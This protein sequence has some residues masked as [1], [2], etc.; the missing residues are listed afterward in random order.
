MKNKG[1]VFI[2]VVICSMLSGCATHSITGE[3]EPDLAARICMEQLPPPPEF[4]QDGHL[5]TTLSVSNIA[6]YDEARQFLFSYYSQYPDIDSDY[7]AVPVAIK[8]LLLPWKW[9]WRNDIVGVLHSQYGGGRSAIDE[10]RQKISNALSQTLTDPQLDWLSGLL[11]HAYADSYAHTKNTFNS[12]EEEAYNVWIGHA[13]PTLF[14][15]SPDNIKTEISE[16]K[17]FAYITDLYS[18]L[19]LDV[20]DDQRFIKF[21]DFVDRL[22]CND[23]ACPNFNALYNNQPVVDTRIDEFIQCMNETSRQLSKEEIQKAIDLIK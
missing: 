12:K 21:K 9:E 18:N 16:P 8:Y 2:V 23:G 5:Y 20:G 10:R 19:K 4:L 6:G 11:I 15:Q 1:A 13:F 17:Y 22:E 14:G 7:E 3:K